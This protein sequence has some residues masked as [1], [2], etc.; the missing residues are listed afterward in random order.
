[1]EFCG[2]PN[3]SVNTFGQ[4]YDIVEAV[5][6]ESVGLVLDCFHFYAMNSD[7]RDLQQADPDNIFLFHI[8]DCEDL[9]IG[10]LR[11]HHRVW[12]GE[13]AIPLKRILDTLKEI[14]YGEMASIELFR[15]EYWEWDADRTIQM[16]KETTEKMVRQPFE[17]G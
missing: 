13:G 11:D 12:P 17:A 4:A 15:P 1:M 7:I 3:C 16:G 14:G 6:R 5:N 10:S 8:D 9:P 2:Y